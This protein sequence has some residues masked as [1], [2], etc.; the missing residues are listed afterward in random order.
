MEDK[1]KEISQIILEAKKVVAFTGAGISAE[2]GIPTFRGK[3][4][5]WEKYSPAI[6]GNLPGLALTFLLRPKKLLQFITD[7][8]ETFSRA[9]PNPAHLAL[10]RLEK[11]GRLSSVITQNIDNLQ[12]RGGC[13]NVIKLHGDLYRLRCLKCNT[14][15]PLDPTNFGLALQELGSTQPGRF[16]MIQKIREAIP[17]CL[18]CGGWMR[19]DIVFFGEG[20]PQDEWLHAQS[21]A[22]SCDLMMV[23]GTSGLIQPAASIPYLAKS[24]GA[25][26]A[27]ITQERSPI[28]PFVD[29]ILL[30]KAGEIMPPIVE[31]VEK[32][33]PK[34]KIR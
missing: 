30:G 3:G 24:G 14:Q 29:Y 9:Q 6:Y 17:R 31:A 18:D 34:Q 26:I 11:R 4:G 13:R 15:R 23:I 10:G 2:S 5:I 28:S 12:E 21:E 32:G 7:A 16:G 33:L 19:P 20:L 1:I 27:E 25:T 8:Y 22:Q